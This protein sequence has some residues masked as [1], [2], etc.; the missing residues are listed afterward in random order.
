MVIDDLY[1]HTLCI[2]YIT[3]FF[4]FSLGSIKKTF[5]RRIK[6]FDKQFVTAFHRRLIPANQW[7]VDQIM[8]TPCTTATSRQ[9]ELSAVDGLKVTAAMLQ[10][11]RIGTMLRD[12][13]MGAFLALFRKR[14]G[15]IAVSHRDV[16]NENGNHYERFQ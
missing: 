11:L 9:R 12:D 5:V 10:Q 6:E 14:D 1:H 16:I 2:L 15:R 4:C 7:L 13:L 8:N 3:Y